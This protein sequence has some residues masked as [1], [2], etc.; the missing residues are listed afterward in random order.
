MEIEIK[1]LKKEEVI[2]ILNKAFELPWFIENNAI[3]IVDDLLYFDIVSIYNSENGKI[4]KIDLD[5][6]YDGIELFIK[7]GGSTNISSYDI[8]D[9]DKILQYTMFGKLLYHITITKTFLKDK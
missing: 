9:C 6:L 4:Y 8:V 1:N 7:N 2:A 5:E 3:D